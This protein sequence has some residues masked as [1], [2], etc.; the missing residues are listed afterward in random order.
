MIRQRVRS[1]KVILLIA[2][3][4]GIALSYFAAFWISVDFLGKSLEPDRYL[5]V[6]PWVLIGWLVVFRFSNLYNIQLRG[7]EELLALVKG[8]LIAVLVTLGV[9][10]FYR[11]TLEDQGYFTFSRTLLVLLAFLTIPTSFIFRKILRWGRYRLFK[12][13]RHF[14]RLI[15]IGRNNVGFMLANELQKHDL[16]YEL[17]G[18][19]EDDSPANNLGGVNQ[20]SAEPEGTAVANPLELTG[21]ECWDRSPAAEISDG[22]TRP[23]NA[24]RD[25]SANAWEQAASKFPVVG[26]IDQVAQIISDRDVS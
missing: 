26:R 16:G 23:E 3:A 18:F 17:V 5:D 4:L 15:I 20:T 1:Y 21:S 8:V 25:T 6:F 13:T 2:D 7:S 10:F 12:S 22:E 19:V 9:A 11:P 14:N 24:D